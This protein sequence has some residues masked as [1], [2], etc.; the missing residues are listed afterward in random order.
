MASDQLVLCDTHSHIHDDDYPLSADEVLTKA[1]AAGVTKIVTLAS[2]LRSAG[3]A[4]QYVAQHDCEQ[5]V[6][7]RACVGVY[8]HETSG[9]AM[10]DLGLMQNMLDQHI[11]QICGIG[12]IGLDYHSNEVGRQQQIAALEGQ[13]QLAIDNDLPMSF[14]VRSGDYGDA[15]AD[16]WA[17]LDNFGGLAK[18]VL[19]SFTDNL[20]N[21][22]KVLNHN[23]YVGVNGI[24]TFN[25]D[26]ELNKVYAQVPLE[27]M[28]LE[29]DAPYLA[30]KPYRGKVDQPAYIRPIAEYVAQLRNVSLEELAKITTANAL[31]VYPAL[32]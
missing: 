19:H 25:K 8:P 4:L 6:T 14:H 9:F 15:F 18:G 11:D 16:F 5:V 26:P 20:A 3:Q 27:R 28:V 17:V 1:A 23:L 2:N 22:D 29:T 10:Q 7:V 13:I 24:V 21:L 31:A 32:A 30:P 12:E